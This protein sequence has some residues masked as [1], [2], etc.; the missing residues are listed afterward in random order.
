MNSSARTSGL[1]FLLLV[2]VALA[3]RSE[4]TVE[5]KRSG[6]PGVFPV[7]NYDGLGRKVVG[8]AFLVDVA[9]GWFLTSAHVLARC[10]NDQ[11]SFWLRVRFE[12]GSGKA[13]RQYDLL[14]KTAWVARGYDFRAK[15]TKEEG[16]DKRLGIAATD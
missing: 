10:T 6:T 9:E 5:D 14:V 15:G 13:C 1:A 2:C 7:Y 16:G 11:T 3:A 4:I 12:V 8:S